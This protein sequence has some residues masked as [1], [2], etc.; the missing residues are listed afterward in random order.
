MNPTLLQLMFKCLTT[1]YARFSGRATRKEYLSLFLLDIIFGVIVASVMYL[2]IPEELEWDLEERKEVVYAI[3]FFGLVTLSLIIPHISVTVRRLHDMS[4][5]GWWCMLIY[6]SG[7]VL[8]IG[9]VSFMLLCLVKGNKHDNQFG[10]SPYNDS[11]EPPVSNASAIILLVLIIMASIGLADFIKG[12]QRISRSPQTITHTVNA[13]PKMQG[14]QSTNAESEPELNQ[15]K[16]ILQDTHR[17]LTTNTS[18]L[19]KSNI[20]ISPNKMLTLSDYT[21]VKECAST[22]CKNVAIIP[23]YKTVSVTQ[24]IYGKYYHNG[25]VHIRYEGIF[26]T[27]YNKACSDWGNASFSGWIYLYANNITD[28]EQNNLYAP[29]NADASISNNANNTQAYVVPSYDLLRKAFILTANAHIRKCASIKCK[30]IAVIPQYSKVIVIQDLEGNY[31][32]DGWVHIYYEGNFCM[33]Y[34]QELNQCLNWKNANLNG[35]VHS[36]LLYQF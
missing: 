17:T 7:L 30:S 14:T 36:R 2:T 4:L 28:T 31:F 15:S 20:S 8:V 6:A 32:Y 13:L 25:W 1:H 24:D 11:I 35:W 18:S 29:I 5:S 21:E 22:E 33:I 12:I 3:I 10:E 19:T 23:Q 34:S 9:I 27:N 26:C 16:N